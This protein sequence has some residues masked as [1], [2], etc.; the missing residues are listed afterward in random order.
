VPV[1]KY[2]DARDMPPVPRSGASDLAARIRALWTRAFLL[3]PPSPPRGVQ[4]FRC[5]E[6]ANAA[7]AEAL[8]Q[9]M[10]RTLR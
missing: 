7:R 4:R 9:R 5:I 1:T 6:D 2:R 3:C 8:R 10:R